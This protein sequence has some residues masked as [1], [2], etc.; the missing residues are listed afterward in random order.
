MKLCLCYPK[1]GDKSQIR[2]VRLKG[3]SKNDGKVL[4]LLLFTACNQYTKQSGDFID[5]FL[6][7]SLCHSNENVIIGGEVEC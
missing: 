3:G 5:I 1:S 2:M 6:D 7:N 4:F